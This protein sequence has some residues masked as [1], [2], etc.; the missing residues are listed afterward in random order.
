[1]KFKDLEFKSHPNLPS[2]TQAVASFA[3]GYKASVVTGRYAYSGDGLYELA[4]ILNGAC[5]YTTPIT[6]DVVGYIN[7]EEVE[8]LLGEIEALPR[9]PSAEVDQ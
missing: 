3:N 1:M 5:C 8:R 4:V 7:E 9:D 2:C 6:D